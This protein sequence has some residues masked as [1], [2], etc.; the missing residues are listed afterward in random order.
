MLNFDEFIFENNSSDFNKKHLSEQETFIKRRV[1]TEMKLDK[2][3][4]G[5][6]RIVYKLSPKRI[7]K[8][9]KNGKGVAQNEVESDYYVQDNYEHGITKVY[10]HDPGYYWLEAEYAKKISKSRFKQ[11]T[12]VDWDTWVSLLLITSPTV[13][14]TTANRPPQDIIDSIYEHENLS[15]I[16]NLISDFTLMCGD[17]VRIN[18]YGEVVRDGKPAVVLTDYGLNQFVYDEYYK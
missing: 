7:I 5:S 12:G 10:D 2:I 8:L 6:G 17:I 18:S 11:I 13:I 3:S 16:I 1:Y 14:K 4:S 9:A 15:E